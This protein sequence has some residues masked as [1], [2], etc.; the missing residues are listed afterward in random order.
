MLSIYDDNKEN[1]DN[2]LIKADYNNVTP[3]FKSI[4][5]GKIDLASY[6]L[7]RIK[8][9]SQIIK[10][11]NQEIKNT[12][13]NIFDVINSEKCKH[14]IKTYVIAL[15][16][17]INTNKIKSE[18]FVCYFHWLCKENDVD[19]IKQLLN[20]FKKENNYMNKLL[21]SINAF[22]KQS[23][24]H[25]ACTND[26]F[27]MI[28]YLLSFIR[29]DKQK[30]ELFSSQDKNGETVLHLTFKKS[31]VECTKLI[32]NKLKSNKTLLSQIIKIETNSTTKDRFMK[33]CMGLEINTNKMDCCS[34]LIDYNIDDE[35]FK[36]LFLIII[37]KQTKGKED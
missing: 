11:F 16:R 26:S 33:T 24:L 21:K 31:Q 10:I 27:E 25:I 36:M 20:V 30:E 19:S 17:N 9:E 37:K 14:I 23:A 32:L 6:I 8:N 15:L 7:D 4:E 5:H 29:D 34:L 35:I 1:S 18:A 28:E 12:N 2:E 3:L 13:K 22:N